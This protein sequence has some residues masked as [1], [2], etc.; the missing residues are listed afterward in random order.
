MI[1]KHVYGAPFRSETSFPFDG[2]RSGSGCEHANQSPPRS[3]FPVAGEVE[4]RRAAVFQPGLVAITLGVLL[5]HSANVFAQLKKVKVCTPGAGTGSMHI[6]A[7]KDRGYFTQE[8]LDVDVLVTRGQICTMALINGQMEVTTNPNVFDAMVAGKFKGKVIYV[9][10]KTLGH[11]FMVAPDIKNFA[12]LKHKS[13]AISTFGGLTD[14]LTREIFEQNALQP[15]KDV[16]MLQLGTPDL[17]YSALKA[18]AVKGAL[19]SSTQAITARREGFRELPYQQPPW[20]SSPIAAGNDL[21][22]KE[23]PMLRGFIKAVSKGHIYYG[24]H[25]AQAIAL[26]QKIQRIADASIAK[27]IYDDDM[28]RQNPGGGMDEAAQRKVVER[29]REMFKVQ[30][31]VELSEIF[32]LNIAREVDAELKKSKWEP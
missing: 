8:G 12:D 17:R 24:R 3:I 25:P 6:Y 14:M 16:A 22:G 2:G 31:K 27:Q 15:N 30:N 13:V 7:A 21:L 1:K 11:R 29:A 9:T 18:G 28:L 26:T 19:V 20:M 23:R 4:R 10:A 5:L 32:D